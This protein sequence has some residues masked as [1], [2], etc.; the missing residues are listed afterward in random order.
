MFTERKGK[1]LGEFYTPACVVRTIVEVIQPFN[2]HVYETI[3]P[4][5]M[6]LNGHRIMFPLAG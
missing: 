1:K 2:D 6:I 4:G 3:V 5:L